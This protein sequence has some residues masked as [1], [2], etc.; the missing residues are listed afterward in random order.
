MVNEFK[1]TI[2]YFARPNPMHMC[3]CAWIYRLIKNKKLGKIR[4]RPPGL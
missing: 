1:P 3:P 4:T 2:V